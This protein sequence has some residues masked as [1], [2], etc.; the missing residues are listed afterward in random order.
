MAGGH[1]D[2]N[3]TITYYTNVSYNSQSATTQSERVAEGANTTITIPDIDDVFSN[4]VYPNH[5]FICWNSS[6]DGTGTDYTPEDEIQINSDITF[7][8]K[9]EIITDENL[10]ISKHS[11]INLADGIRQM[12]PSLKQDTLSITDMISALNNGGIKLKKILNDNNLSYTS[13]TGNGIYISTGITDL[14]PFMII[15]S[16]FENN[17]ASN[18]S[19]GG[20]FFGIAIP[21]ENGEYDLTKYTFGSIYPFTLQYCRIELINGEYK[22]YVAGT[23][24]GK[25]L[26]LRAPS[27]TISNAGTWGVVYTL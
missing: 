22:L 11:L 13:G 14:Q 9:W 12:S 2:I 15:V 20:T 5:S 8:A 6:I 3:Y 7:Y 19:T 16:T 27:H 17:T 24:G 25:T 23:L 21:N 1:S 18:Y 4:F 26:Y 10:I